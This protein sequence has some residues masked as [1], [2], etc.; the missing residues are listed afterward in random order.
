VGN[1]RGVRRLAVAF[2][3]RNRP[4]N[5]RATR[6]LTRVRASA[7]DNA[8]DVP[9]QARRGPVDEGI[10]PSS[11]VIVSAV[12]STS[13]HPALLGLDIEALMSALGQIQIGVL[14]SF[15]YGFAWQGI[16][17]IY[18]NR[19]VQRATAE[20]EN[21]VPYLL[22]KRRAEFALFDAV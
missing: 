7:G 22:E 15:T 12:P 21:C 8:E 6:P 9:R 20:L 18:V 14:L 4:G 11:L 17:L 1:S 16:N 19:V 3:P 2:D 10:C 13:R 5:E